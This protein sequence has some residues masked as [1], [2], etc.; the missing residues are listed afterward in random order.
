MPNVSRPEVLPAVAREHAW[1]ALWQLLLQP[2]PED[3]PA[4]E[5]SEEPDDESTAAD[6]DTAS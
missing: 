3:S 2:V 4:S 5:P 6:E 1:S